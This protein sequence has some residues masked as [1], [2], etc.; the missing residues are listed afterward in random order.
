MIK[1]QSK[2]V[3]RKKRH[4]RIRKHLSGTPERP[5]LSVYRSNR[6]FYVQLI[7]DVNHHTLV[8]VHSKD[9]AKGANIK[10][11][12][13]VG[14]ELAKKAKESKITKIV[15]DR[16]GYLYHGRIKALAEALRASGLEF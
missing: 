6:E 7:D 12:T 2:N 1:K 13:L 5:R 10:T 4:L 16:S 3:L 8:A 9:I 11:A 15:F 14:E